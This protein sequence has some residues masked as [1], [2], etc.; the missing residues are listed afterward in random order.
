MINTVMAICND[1]D[2]ATSCGI[3]S[4][5]TTCSETTSNTSSAISNH[6]LSPTHLLE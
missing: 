2:D 1:V 6:H 3:A 5:C 4:N